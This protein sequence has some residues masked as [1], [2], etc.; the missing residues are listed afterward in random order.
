ML[1]EEHLYIVKRYRILKSI[2]YFLWPKSRCPKIDK[3]KS[4]GA[5]VQERGENRIIFT[6]LRDMFSFV[7]GLK[8]NW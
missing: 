2:G 3:L 8:T 1:G 4:T 5:H 7:V 6:L